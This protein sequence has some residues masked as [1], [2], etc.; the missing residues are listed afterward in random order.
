[1]YAT[2][3]DQALIVQM[4]REFATKSLAP[5]AAEWDETHHFP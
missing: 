3:E 1:M 2:T 5:H 4:V